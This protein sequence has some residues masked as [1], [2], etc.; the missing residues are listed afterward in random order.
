MHLVRTR[1][2]F[3]VLTVVLSLVAAA[4]ALAGEPYVVDFFPEGQQIDHTIQLRFLGPSEGTITNVRLNV[5]FTTAA[6]FNA[7]DLTILLV[8]PVAG[9]GNFWFLTGEDL[10]WTGQG[11]FHANINTNE[12]NGA[13]QD[14]LWANDIGSVLDPPAYSGTFS[15]TSHFEVD[16]DPVPEPACGLVAIGSLVAVAMLRRR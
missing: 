11:T 3:R 15:D 9:E 8:A 12:M 13:L 4:P 2:A 10:G 16:I 6:G 14:G 7:Q 5:D 1:S